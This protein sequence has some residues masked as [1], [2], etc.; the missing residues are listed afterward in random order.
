MSQREVMCRKYGRMLPAL[1]AA[2]FPGELG[3]DLHRNVSALAWREWQKLQTMLINE[4]RL[5]M[6]DAEARKYLQDQMRKFFAGE[7]HDTPSG[8]VPPEID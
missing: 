3:E 8:Y 1:S 2:P 4:K 6:R 7:A 5:S